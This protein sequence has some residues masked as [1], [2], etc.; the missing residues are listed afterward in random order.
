MGSAPLLEADRPNVVSQGSS[1]SGLAV[2]NRRR[3]NTDDSIPMSGHIAKIWQSLTAA[4]QERTQAIIAELTQQERMQWLLELATLSL[5]DAVARVRDVIRPR[6]PAPNR[7]PH[8][9]QS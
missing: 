1:G 2:R 3:A 6:A 4:E 9:A 7:G 5:P 8:G